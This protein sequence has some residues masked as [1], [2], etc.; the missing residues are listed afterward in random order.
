MTASHAESS[1][2]RDDGDASPRRPRV[3]L[4]DPQGAGERSLVSALAEQGYEVEGASGAEEGLSL[5]R[6]FRPDLALCAWSDE[7][8]DGIDYCRR[9]KSDPELRGTY[10]VLRSSLEDGRCPVEGL[11]AG[12]DDFLPGQLETDELLARVR[13]GL[14]MR[15]LQS[16]LAQTQHRAALLEIAATLGH[17]INNPLTALYGHMELVRQYL[18]RG[19]VDRLEH[20]LGQAAEVAARIGDVAKRLIELAEP[21]MKRY[22]GEQ[23]MLD[24]ERS[25]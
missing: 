7:A 22:L 2:A 19:D 14:R 17:E 10:V 3:L 25:S 24:L 15:R 13:A 4:I 18:E 5:T 8:Q 1:A 11:D 16:E 20:H 23:R 21:R 12:A 6:T 9:V